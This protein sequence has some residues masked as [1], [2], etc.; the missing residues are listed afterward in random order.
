M[1]KIDYSR[2]KRLVF[3]HDIHHNPPADG[4]DLTMKGTLNV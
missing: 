1:R 2:V 3:K 4:L